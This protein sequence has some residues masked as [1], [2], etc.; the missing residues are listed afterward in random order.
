MQ[1]TASLKAASEPLSLTLSKSWSLKRYLSVDKKLTLNQ[2]T[3]RLYTGVKLLL[4][5]M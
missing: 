5:S 4:L 3:N 1:E 2:S